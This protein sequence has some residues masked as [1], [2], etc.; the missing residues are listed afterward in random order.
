[1]YNNDGNDFALALFCFYTRIVD[2]TDLPL[3]IYFILSCFVIRRGKRNGNF[4]TCLSLHRAINMPVFLQK[5]A[6]VFRKIS[7]NSDLKYGHLLLDLMLGC[8]HQG[9]ARARRRRACTREP[10]VTPQIWRLYNNGIGAVPKC[11]RPVTFLLRF[12]VLSERG[13][14]R[15]HSTGQTTSFMGKSCDPGVLLEQPRRKNRR[16]G[17]AGEGWKKRA[18]TLFVYI[19][20]RNSRERR[21]RETEAECSTKKGRKYNGLCIVFLYR[22]CQFRW[23]D[24]LMYFETVSLL[25]EIFAFL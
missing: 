19:D 16:V 6:Q 15:M 21:S 9:A 10:A 7:T 17:S 12:H 4:Q 23:M 22:K 3:P 24:I 11:S 25:I 14:P 5:C 20:T 1:M 13:G 8:N 2:E 18:K